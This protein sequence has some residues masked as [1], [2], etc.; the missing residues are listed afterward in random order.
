MQPEVAPT[1]VLHEETHWR[2]TLNAM[3]VAMFFVF[4]EGTFGAAFLPVF[5]QHD[6]HL[7]MH[8][9]ELWTGYMI[10]IP[11]A[12]MFLAQPLWGMYAD[13]HG[14]KPIVIIGV[15]SASVLRS[16]WFFAHSPVTLVALGACAG[17]L[18]A[19]VVTGQAILAS[20]APRGA[21]G[22]DHGQ[23]ADRD[24]RRI[25]HRPGDRAGLR[26]RDRARPTFLLQALFALIG[27]IILGLFV[28]ERFQKPERPVTGASLK[29]SYRI[30]A[31]SWSATGNSRCSS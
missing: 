7:T 23:I 16:L 9:A 31:K 24:D 21:P 29:P 18:G 19:G 26:G 5:L 6:L 12:T 3:W 27:A 22:R 4:L 30:P 11:S 2:R 14:R 20:A 1:K 10:V 13:R 8:Q 25:P 17:A 28:E 15:V